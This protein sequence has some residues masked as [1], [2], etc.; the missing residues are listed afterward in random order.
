MKSLAAR[1]SVAIQGVMTTLSEDPDLDL[2]QLRR[3]LLITDDLKSAGLQIGLRHVSSSFG[4]FQHPDAF[5]D[6][7]RPGMAVFGMYSEPE[8]RELEVLDLRPAVSLKARVAYVKQLPAG[9]TAGYDKAYVA[10]A[11]VWIATLPV[12]HADGWPR[13]TAGGAGVKINGSAY[14]VIASVSASH[15][16]VEI[17]PEPRVSIGDVA[18]MFDWEDGS[19]PE[20]VAAACG[21]SVYDL[22][23]HLN[24][25]MTRKVV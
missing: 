12:G 21:S 7:V 3:L 4:L 10:T 1:S 16:I 13:A 20:D 15:T 5:L 9:G 23:I 11:P 14:P 19:R 25:L 2:E 8:F 24:P 6:M 22:T 18:T 17:G